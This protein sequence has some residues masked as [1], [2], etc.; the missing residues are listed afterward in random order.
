MTPM[1]VTGY[2]NEAS[3][4]AV[5]DYIQPYDSLRQ[6]SAPAAGALSAGTDSSDHNYEPVNMYE[7]PDMYESLQNNPQYAKLE[8]KRPAV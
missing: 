5:G 3:Y 7:R 6:P 2:N 4:D 1:D 8:P